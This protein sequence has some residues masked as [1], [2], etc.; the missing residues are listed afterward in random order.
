MVRL[1]DDLVLVHAGCTRIGGRHDLERR[2]AAAPD[3]V[4]NL[5]YSRAMA[6]ARRSTGR[7]QGHPMRRGIISTPVVAAL[8]LGTGRDVAWS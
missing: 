3:Y 8:C 4:A 7:H 2:C 6:S 5:R 1:F